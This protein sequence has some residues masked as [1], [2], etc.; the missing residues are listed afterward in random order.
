MRY[1]DV[2]GAQQPFP[3][4]YGPLNTGAVLAAIPLVPG[5]DGTFDFPEPA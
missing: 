1:E 5:P 4:I 3:H 2:P